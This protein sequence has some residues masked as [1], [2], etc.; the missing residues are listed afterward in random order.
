MKLHNLSNSLK[1]AYRGTDVTRR[2]QQFDGWIDR[3]AELGGATG[4][5][6]A[7]TVKDYYNLCSEFMVFGW[8]DSLH[9][10]PLTPH[11]SLEDAIVRHQRSMISK[12][13][14][15]EGMTVVD[16][17]CGVGGPMRR[18]VRESGVRIVG[19]NNSDI[20]LEKAK[21]LNDEAG[22]SHMIDYVACSFMDMGAIE[23]GTFDRGYAIESTCHAPDKERA[24]A[25][26][27][28][29][30][31]PGALFWGQEMCLTDKF[32]PTDS[33][34]QAIKRELMRG[35]ALQDV[36]TMAEV[37]HALEA[38]GFQVI[39]AMDRDVQ[40][41]PSTPWYQ[42]MESRHGTLSNALRRLPWGRRAFIAGA[43]LAEILRL[44]PKGSS[45]VVALLDR[46]ADAYVA[47]G[48][49]EIFT[50]LYCFL[51]RKPFGTPETISR[52]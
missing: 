50:P 15:R 21:T 29:I 32:D 43:K 25:E 16:V 17:G 27:F 2:V 11:E 9:F 5:D 19:I 13:E 22:L 42:P 37:K 33:R 12:L 49:A 23:D 46:T 35:I 39:E 44:F 36:A 30:L 52:G 8:S 48:K 31:K 7:E 20:Q 28:R 47:G 45:E 3:T 18:V 51:A 4:Y 40:E 6:H 10:A 38:A 26:I 34:H 1:D 24:F 14:L 41:G